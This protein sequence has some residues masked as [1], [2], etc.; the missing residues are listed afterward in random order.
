MSHVGQAKEGPRTGEGRG[1]LAWNEDW[2]GTT[3]AQRTPSSS[4]RRQT[5]AKADTGGGKQDHQKGS[6]E[7]TKGTSKSLYA[8]AGTG[9]SCDVLGG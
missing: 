6:K 4:S 2:S 8:I 3:G 1:L 5:L 7:T 9:G